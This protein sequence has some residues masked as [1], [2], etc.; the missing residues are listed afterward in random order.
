MSTLAAIIYLVGIASILVIP[1]LIGVYV[2]RDASRRGMNAALWVII[3]LLLSFAGFVIYLL[4][5]QDYLDMQCPTCCSPV[6]RQD[7]VC[8]KCNAKLMIS[9]SK[10]GLTAEADWM[11]CPQCTTPLPEHKND[12][13]A[14][15]KKKDTALVKILVLVAAVPI[16]FVLVGIIVGLPFRNITTTDG[17]YTYGG[18]ASIDDVSAEDYQDNP[19][20]M[21]WLNKCS[22][23]T[24][25]TYALCYQAKNGDLKET[26]YLLYMP[27]EN[28]FVSMDEGFAQGAR[29]FDV[30][31]SESTGSFPVKNE[32]LYIVCNSPRDNGTFMELRVFINDKQIDY[33]ITKI[34]YNPSPHGEAPPIVTP[35]ITMSPIITMR[36]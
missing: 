7:I 22:E 13:L 31:Y 20:I 34:N 23:D 5:R 29:Y 30:K 16:L 19:E 33:E 8:P 10:C 9:C 35:I 11:V 28:G 2:Y 18:Y 4:V 12:Y 36:R 26:S 3:V 32:L 14:P 27:T 1:I 17:G 15:T 24:S 25:K 6:T 21:A